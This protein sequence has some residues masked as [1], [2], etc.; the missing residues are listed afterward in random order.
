MTKYG[1]MCTKSICDALKQ[2]VIRLKTTCKT[3]AYCQMD[4][5]LPDN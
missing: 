1:E 2:I 3:C 4:E 5:T